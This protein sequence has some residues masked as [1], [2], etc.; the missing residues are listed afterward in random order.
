MQRVPVTKA[1]VGL[2][3][4]LTATGF[5]IKMGPHLDYETIKSSTKSAPDDIARVRKI[6]NAVSDRLPPPSGVA[7]ICM[8]N[9]FTGRIGTAQQLIALSTV[10]RLALYEDGYP[11]FIIS[12]SQLKKFASGKG[13]CDKSIVVREVY[14]RWGVDATDDNQ[15]DAAVL[16]HI[17][18]A[19]VFGGEL[20]KFQH[21]T[22]K[23]ILK[24]GKNY[25]YLKCP[26]GSS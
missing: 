22:I 7:M 21:E 19:L 3:M 11:F 24:E 13:N 12:P 10:M 5:C 1:V 18:H 17:A 23:K 6:V 9:Y 25:N 14:K 26:A 16:A 4:S 20:T 8:E 15:A 2:D